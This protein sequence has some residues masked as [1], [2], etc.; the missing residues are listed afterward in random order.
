ML[1]INYRCQINRSAGDISQFHQMSFLE[2]KKRT[3]WG[4]TCEKKYEELKGGLGLTISYDFNGQYQQCMECRKPK[5][6][7]PFC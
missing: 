4:H 2:Q 1:F 7:A 5:V 3:K 6:T